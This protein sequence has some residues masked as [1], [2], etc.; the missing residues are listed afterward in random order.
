MSTKN[1]P[2]RVFSPAA[3]AILAI[4]IAPAAAHAQDALGTGH[5]LDANLSPTSGG[6]NTPT[7]REDYRLPNLIVTDNVIGGR[8]FRGTVGYVAEDAFRQDL[9]EVALGESLGSDDLYQFRANAAISDPRY[10]DYG[11]TYE[12]FRFGQD[13]ALLEYRRVGESSSARALQEGLFLQQSELTEARMRLDRLALGASTT[14]SSERAAEPI[15]LG[16]TMR[17]GIN[18]LI[19]ASPFAGLTETPIDEVGQIIGLTT[20]DLARLQ[21]DAR[22]GNDELN[23]RLGQRYVSNYATLPLGAEIGFDPAG[24]RL[25]QL[26]VGVEPTNG[27]APSALVGETGVAG[28]PA[29]DV[30][31]ETELLRIQQQV[32]QRFSGITRPGAGEPGA[33]LDDQMLLELEEDLRALRERLTGNTSPSFDA[34]L[35]SGLRPEESN[36]R[37]DLRIQPLEEN[38][39]LSARE[40]AEPRRD[41]LASGDEIPMPPVPELRRPLEEYGLILKHG[42]RVERLSTGEDDRFNELLNSAEARLRQGK[43]FWAERRF[44]RALR[45]VPGHPMATAGLANTQIGAGLYLSA[46]ITLRSLFT[47]QPEM[48]DVRYAPELLPSRPRLLDAIDTLEGRI[49]TQEDRSAAAFI[50]AYLGH[51]LEERAYVTRGLAIMGEDAPNDPLLPLL[52]SVWLADESP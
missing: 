32:V 49:R 46:S 43:Y 13:L 12:R 23:S 17:D 11:M 18:V 47:Y 15:I 1:K 20:Y 29:T 34:V 24:S 27:L 9:A 28:D 37:E 16:G 42:Q 51:I 22:M 3:T 7:F 5:A 35:S 25:E 30:T 10:S 14:A 21:Q 6:I 19:R 41:P 38:P 31:G 8:G 39:L 44:N 50:L 33:V 40:P 36:T 52:R 48:I 26:P 4:V 2:G 45:F